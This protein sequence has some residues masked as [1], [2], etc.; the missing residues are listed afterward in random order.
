M[1]RRAGS[2]DEVDPVRA[3]LAAAAAAPPKQ[4]ES[5]SQEVQREPV[6]PIAS[7][8]AAP[9]E[10]RIEPTGR[11]RAQRKV[12]KRASA[13]R[14]NTVNKKTLVTREEAELID[15]AVAAVS[16]AFGSKV[17]FSQI[18]RAMWAILSESEDAVAAFGRRERGYRSLPS[19]GNAAAMAEYEAAVGQF[20]AEALRARR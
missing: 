15:E 11:R 4:Q 18:T 13:P 2:E 8:E 14:A 17:T 1:P 16:A 9:R 6:E 20:I 3:R 7:T 10:Q 5:P 12:R 19:T